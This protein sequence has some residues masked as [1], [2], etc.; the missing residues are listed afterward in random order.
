MTPAAGEHFW[1]LASRAS[2]IVALGLVTFSVL[3]GLAMAGKSAR[4]PGLP[5]TLMAV[6]EQTAL[7]SMVAIALHGLTLLGDG[8]MRPSLGD[9][10][11]PFTSTLDPIGVGVGVV[12]GYL[13]ALLGLTYY[14]RRRLGPKLWRTAHRFTLLV[15]VM[16]VAHTL[17]VGTDA[18][19]APMRWMMVITGAPALFFLVIRLLPRG[20]D[21]GGT[22]R[23]P[24]P[25]AGAPH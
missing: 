11:I 8:F 17:A 9:I 1:W 18:G 2:G 22:Y 14:F 7:A 16:A 21:R 20:L 25:P 5:R 6:H 3:L 23:R 13:G 19:G 24:S 10:F 4:R 15:Y 12:A